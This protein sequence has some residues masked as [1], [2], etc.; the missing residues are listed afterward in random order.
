MRYLFLILLCFG[1]S[2]CASHTSNTLKSNFKDGKSIVIVPKP[3]VHDKHIYW[4]RAGDETIKNHFC[5]GY[6]VGYGYTAAIMEAGT[7]YIRKLTLNDEDTKNITS[8][9]KYASDIGYVTIIKT[10]EKKTQK[11]YQ[12]GGKSVEKTV[13]IKSY[14]KTYG[15]FFDY[16]AIGFVTIEPNEVVLLSFVS[17]DVD[18]AENACEVVNNKEKSFLLEVLGS[19]KKTLLGRVWDAMDT[20]NGF[21]TWEWRCPVKAFYVTIETKNVSDFLTRVDKKSFPSDMLDNIQS[22]GFQFG[23]S[24][25]KAQKLKMFIPSIEQYE[26]KNLNDF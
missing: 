9:D 4:G 1:L 26:I 24:L 14:Y 22:R 23:K 15:Y 2:G 16:D 6:D 7:Y 3:M 20:E 13:D 8:N 21:E 5:S 18:I 19:D 11:E 17:I 12:G 25:E 10:P